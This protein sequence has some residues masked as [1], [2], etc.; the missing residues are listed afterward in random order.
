MRLGRQRVESMREKNRDRMRRWCLLGEDVRDVVPPEL[1][2]KGAEGGRGDSVGD[3]GELDI[4][5]A[6]GEVCWA[7]GAGDKG[8]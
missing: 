3:A 2:A 5:C 1:K 7:R 8:L 6:R 4:K